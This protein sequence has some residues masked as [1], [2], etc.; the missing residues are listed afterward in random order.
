MTLDLNMKRLQKQVGSQDCACRL[1]SIPAI[2]K[3]DDLET[4]YLSDI[5]SIARMEEIPQELILNWD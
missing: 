5:E 1:L 4:Q 3:V 2:S